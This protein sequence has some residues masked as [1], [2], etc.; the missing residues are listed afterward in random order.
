MEPM[1]AKKHQVVLEPK[2]ISVNPYPALEK[3]EEKMLHPSCV[4]K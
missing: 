2:K 3:K 1:P 4:G